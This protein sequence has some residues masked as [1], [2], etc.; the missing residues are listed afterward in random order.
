M[1]SRSAFVLS[2]LLAS[3]APMGCSDA[4]GD[5]DALDDDGG[6]KADDIAPEDFACKS[7]TGITLEA[8][9]QI[10]DP[11]AA[12]LIK[13][14]EGC[15]ADYRAIVERLRTV[16]PEG[17]VAG[18]DLVTRIVS[19]DARIDPNPDNYRTVT[20]RACGSRPNHSILWTLLGV[21]ANEDIGKRTFV[22]M[23]ALDR[24][25]GLYNFWVFNGSSFTFQGN[26]L[27]AAAGTISCGGCHRDGGVLM[28]ELDDPWIHWESA[29][30]PLPGVDALFAAHAPMFGE[31][32]NG[33][34]LE[35]I[36]RTGND[37]IV[38][39]RID[40]QSN[41][42]TGN[43]ATL[44]RPLFCAEQVNLDTAGR[45][46]D[47]PVAAIPADLLLDPRWG[48]SD[49]VTIDPAAYE[50]AVTAAGQVVPGVNGRVDTEFKLVF[51]ERAGFDDAYLQALVARGIIDEDFL[52]DVLAVDFTRPLFSDARCGLLTFAPAFGEPVTG[53]GTSSGDDGSSSD[54]SGADDGS[55]GG[56]DGTVDVGDCCMAGTGKG[57]S[58]DTIEACVCAK[59]DFCCSS[60]WDGT[61]VSEVGSLGCGMCS[62]P[63][64]GTLPAGTSVLIPA[65]EP[66]AIREAFITALQKSAPA[67]G[68]PA[69]ELL[70]NLMDGSDA[71]THRD[72]TKA[73]VTACDARDD[74]ALADDVL[75][76]VQLT[77]GL[78]KTK[79]S[80]IEHAE[81]LAETKLQV[82]TSAHLDPTTCTLVD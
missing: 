76:F 38:S 23:Q 35:Q 55:G 5:D 18:R 32:G 7:V 16:D 36:V 15:P 11:I 14:G 20:S 80:L 22:E 6:G 29:G 34:E 60:N 50:A 70:A 56:D 24:A 72:R 37:A 62:M 10:D 33:K 44:L 17:C 12:F 25:S 69:A 71:A 28:K 58:N 81:Q 45:E 77:R 75:K 49:G 8:L 31:R 41:A 63:D 42:K 2:I 46:V 13:R 19:D 74:R 4:E 78:V 47:G 51:P 48:I 3:L 53:E 40:A 57:C 61:C 64:P 39:A 66:K 59:D 73:F 21:R 67:A 1:R 26:S 65:A 54:S 82:A 9:A 68:T 79:T 30:N 52:L 43:V 27:Q